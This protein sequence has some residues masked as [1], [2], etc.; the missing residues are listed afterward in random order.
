MS[1]AID[2]AAGRK[3]P[4]TAVDSTPSIVR[5]IPARMLAAHWPQI[6]RC[7]HLMPRSGCGRNWFLLMRGAIAQCPLNKAIRQI[8]VFSSMPVGTKIF[9]KPMPLGIAENL[10]STPLERS[11][12]LAC[13]TVWRETCASRRLSNGRKNALSPAQTTAHS[14]GL[15]FF[16]P[17]STGRAYFLGDRKQVNGF[18]SHYKQESLCSIESL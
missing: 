16:H 14:K 13:S 8:S 6:R 3:N 12:P 9:S 2:S 11:E 17:S 1:D 7:G 10:H 4:L 15:R 5:A 18:H